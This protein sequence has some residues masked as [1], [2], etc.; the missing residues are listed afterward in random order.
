MPL[1]CCIPK[2]VFFFLSEVVFVVAVAVAVVSGLTFSRR[3]Y[4]FA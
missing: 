1:W 2:I 4:V 3:A